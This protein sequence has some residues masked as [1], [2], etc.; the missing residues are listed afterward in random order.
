[1][2][3]RQRLRFLL[4]AILAGALA[5]PAS[6]GQES[7]PTDISPAETVRIVTELDR[8]HFDAFNNCD[9]KTL[10]SLYAPGAEFYHDLSGRVLSGEQ[11]VAAVQKNICGKVQRRLIPG[12]LEVFPMAGFG[13]IARGR[14]CFYELGASNCIQQGQ[15]FMLWKFDGARW[16][17]TRVLSYD[18]KDMR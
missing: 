14:H 8:Q 18:H 6:H 3:I 9:L 16:Q 4:P 13:A 7:G 11:L 2:N 15:F 1:M 10:A 17:L 12:S 5:S